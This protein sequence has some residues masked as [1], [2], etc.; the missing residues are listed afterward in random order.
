MDYRIALMID[1]EN[2][3][4]TY[5]D[6]VMNETS[7]YGKLVIARFYGDISKLSS[8]WKNKAIDYA[9]KP[10]HQFN[11]ATGKNAAD[12]EMALD[13]IEIRYQDKADLFFIVSSDS[14]FT[15]LAIRLKESGAVV[16][17]V[18]DEK[19]V[20]SAFK[21]ACSEFKYFE[22]F[23]ADDEV[24][25]LSKEDIKKRI[26]N[27]IIENGENNRLLLSRLGD[28][29]KNQ[30]SDFDPRKY[31]VSN[32]I[33][34]VEKYGF[35]TI[36]EGTVTYVIYEIDIKTDDIIKLVNDYLGDKPSENMG[37]IKNII[38]K[39]FPDFNVKQLG[40]TKFSKFIESLDYKVVKNTY[41]RK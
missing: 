27:I 5:L 37:K 18:G 2:V 31:G 19:K 16:V 20:T 24:E 35:I 29:L 36:T 7:K 12:M 26:S 3:S 6:H 22:Y 13:A 33:S 8:K 10:M 11:V 40:F 17:G 21:S 25:D 15:P 30:T 41:K 38:D 14:D 28:I 34:L 1:A 9:I 39:E 32:L 23:E 4:H